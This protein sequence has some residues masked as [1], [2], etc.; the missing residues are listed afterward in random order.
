VVTASP[1]LGPAQQAMFSQRYLFEDKGRIR[2][3]S[4]L[5]ALADIEPKQRDA[6]EVLS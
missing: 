1:E 5:G 6:E 3:Y 4:P 2:E